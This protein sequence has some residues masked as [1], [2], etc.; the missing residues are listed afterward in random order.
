VLVEPACQRIEFLPRQRFLEEGTKPSAL[1]S[2][3]GREYRAELARALDSVIQRASTRVERTHPAMLIA[4]ETAELVELL[5]N[6]IRT[7]R[8]RISATS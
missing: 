6:T 3:R 8:L 5:G 4:T 7:S 1:R 2:A